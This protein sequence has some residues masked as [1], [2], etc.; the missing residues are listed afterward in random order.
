MFDF[1]NG[2]RESRQAMHPSLG[3]V[4]LPCPI[5]QLRGTHF[6]FLAAWTSTELLK[7]HLG[8]VGECEV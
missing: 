3:A 5:A 1:P 7:G 8:M 4:P 2:P 6:G